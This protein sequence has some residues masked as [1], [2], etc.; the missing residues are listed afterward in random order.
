MIYYS[1]QHK[2]IMFGEVYMFDSFTQVRSGRSNQLLPELASSHDLGSR[3]PTIATLTSYAN[4]LLFAYPEQYDLVNDMV[5]A[6]LG[7]NLGL[8]NDK[9]IAELQDQLIDLERYLIETKY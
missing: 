3:K 4:S 6:G 2:I 9:S 7:L 1:Y 5:N 8:Y